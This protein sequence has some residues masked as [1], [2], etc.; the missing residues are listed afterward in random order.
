MTTIIMLAGLLLVLLAV[1]VYS[2]LIA[3]SDADDAA[4]LYWRQQQDRER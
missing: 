1:A 2:A 4:E 3:A